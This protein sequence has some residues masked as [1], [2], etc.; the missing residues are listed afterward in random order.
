[1]GM[2]SYGSVLRNKGVG[3]EGPD[4]YDQVGFYFSQSNIGGCDR[5]LYLQAKGA[6]AFDPGNHLLGI[7]EDGE[8][9]EHLTG[10]QLR[11]AGIE[12][13]EDQSP[14]FLE[15]P[16]HP[17][18]ESSNNIAGISF[19][20]CPVCEAR[21][22]GP[23]LHG[24]IDFIAKNPLTG[25]PEIVEHKAIN[26]NWWDATVRAIK[27]GGGAEFFARHKRYAV[28]TGLYL[29][30][31]ARRYRMEAAEGALV[32]KNKGTAKFLD[33]RFRYES[34]SD[35]LRIVSSDIEGKYIMGEDRGLVISNFWALA[36]NKIIRIEQ[37]IQEPVTR[38]LLRSGGD[39][40]S[41]CGAK[42]VCCSE[43]D[44]DLSESAENIYLADTEL[45][46]KIKSFEEIQSRIKSLEKQKKELSADFD[47]LL[48]LVAEARGDLPVVVDPE[49]GLC[50]TLQ[51][52]T[53]TAL[54][55][56]AIENLSEEDRAVLDKVLRQT[57]GKY[58]RIKSLSKAWEK[59]L[60]GAILLN[61]ALPEP[62]IPAKPAVTASSRRVRAG[63]PAR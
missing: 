19:D 6:Y 27:E 16:A 29:V 42:E 38:H 49:S 47:S 53:R 50:L 40:C 61:E 14:S 21:I 62:V 41:N 57:S 13:L 52:W 18:I 7:F 60:G 35:T 58:P 26:P 44:M 5:E 54:D 36:V 11:K 15:L 10:Q 51:R 4:R 25:L 31:L 59:K 63:G 12:I 17:L 55:S 23:C 8:T 28:Q 9:H 48:S 30:D 3:R 56:K 46:E 32:F 45:S 22:V 20:V 34:E 24:H 2:F 1:M 39:K 37:A 33:V 43:F